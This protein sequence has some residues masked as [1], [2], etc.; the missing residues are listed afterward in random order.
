MESSEDEI[1]ARLAEDLEKQGIYKRDIDKIEEGLFLGNSYAAHNK[2]LLDSLGITHILNVTNR[3]DNKFKRNFKYHTIPVEDAASEDIK[4]HFTE[5]IEFIETAL[6]E[7]KLD[8][9]S[10]ARNKVL[11]HCKAGYSRSAT[12][13]TAYFMHKY[14]IPYFEAIERIREKR[15]IDPRKGFKKQLYQ[16][17]VEKIGLE[18]LPSEEDPAYFKEEG[19]H[20][21]F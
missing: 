20:H 5:A 8:C 11:V 16:F 21:F 9:D 7:Q 13:V 15:E 1:L 10:T 4:S 6:E 17:Q 3:I 14:K 2:D 19:T 18:D 12:I